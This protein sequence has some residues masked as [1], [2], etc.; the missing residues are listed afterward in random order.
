MIMSP[1]WRRPNFSFGPMV[2]SKSSTKCPDFTNF[3]LRVASF[4]YAWDRI[5]E[6][7]LSSLEFQNCGQ[8]NQLNSIQFRFILDQWYLNLKADANQNIPTAEG[9]FLKFCNS[10]CKGRRNFLKQTNSI[11]V[12]KCFFC[13]T[14]FCLFTWEE[15]LLGAFPLFL[16]LDGK[17]L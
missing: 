10:S 12:I 11:L 7:S 9:S 15:S 6:S 4:S 5:L 8:Y 16:H 3:L 13:S 1:P 14:I 17:F 2:S